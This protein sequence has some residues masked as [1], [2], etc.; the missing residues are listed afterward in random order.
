MTIKEVQKLNKQLL[1][2]LDDNKASECTLL[3]IRDLTDLADF[4]IIACGSSKRHIYSLAEKTALHAKKSGFKPLGISGNAE[5]DWV[6][7]D[8]GS[9]I[10]H[11]MLPETRE[12]YKLEELWDRN[13]TK[14][15][16]AP[17]K[18]KLKKKIIPKSKSTKKVS[19]TKSQTATATA[20]KK[21]TPVKSNNQ[22]Q[23]I[24]TKTKPKS[25]KKRVKK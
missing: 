9:I 18:S 4:M 12:L 14:L 24:T 19:I 16:L 6:L 3:D 15:A 17:A 11:V 22:L 23:S 13:L 10:I 7:V 1:K 8:L 20:K 21:T 5:S 25:V 2:I